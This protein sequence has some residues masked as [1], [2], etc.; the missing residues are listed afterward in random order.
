VPVHGDWKALIRLHDGRSL[1]AVPVY[2]PDDPAIPVKG[3]PVERRFER[4]FVSD[5]EILQRE[6]RTAAPPLK[7]A[8][9]GTV[10]L[11]ALAILAG[12]AAGLH[13]LALAG[14]ETPLPVRPAGVRRRHRGWRARVA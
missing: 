13:R 11:L 9:Y 10:A 7:V 12:L 14:G 1:T 8:A 3:V 2:L 4:P 5:R 6:A